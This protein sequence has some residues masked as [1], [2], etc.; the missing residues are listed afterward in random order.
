[1]QD[2]AKPPEAIL[3]GEPV[4]LSAS[5]AA[6]AVRAGDLRSLDLVEALQIDWLSHAHQ[7]PPGTHV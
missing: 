6:A 5:A 7:R 4:W 3:P 2:R 1:M